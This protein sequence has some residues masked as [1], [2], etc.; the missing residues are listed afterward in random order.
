MESGQTESSS[1]RKSIRTLKC[2]LCGGNQIYPGPRYENH[3]VKFL[4]IY[5][6]VVLLNPRVRLKEKVIN[7]V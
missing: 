3:L 2:I 4:N 5:T 6:N 1:S 7:E